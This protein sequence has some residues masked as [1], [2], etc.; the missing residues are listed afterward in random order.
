M[1][2]DPMCITLYLLY[3]FLI[4]KHLPN[5]TIYLDTSVLIL[6]IIE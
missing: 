3:K 1:F 2:F 5:K 6:L 4:S